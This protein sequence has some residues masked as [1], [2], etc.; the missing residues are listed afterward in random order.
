MIAKDTMFNVKN[1]STS[2][3]VYRIPEMNIRREW[4]PGETKRISFEEMEKL[5]YQPG[6]RALIVNFLQI[7][8]EELT[9]MFNINRQPEYDMSEQQVVDLIKNGSLDAFLDALDFAPMGV[10]DLIKQLSV[11]LP[12]S[13]PAKREALF[14]K[15]GFDVDKAITNERAD[16]EPEVNKIEE[17]PAERRVKPD[18]S[19]APTRRRTTTNYK[20]V[21]KTDSDK[22]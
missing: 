21:N 6:G 18:G 3:V 10:I 4:Q 11:Q 15:T 8:E 9:N 12:I 19:A 16:K 13:D 2:I 20:V 14:K 22:K 5:S 1:R 17:K 7:K